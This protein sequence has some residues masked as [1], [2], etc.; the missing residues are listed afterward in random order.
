MLNAGEA[1]YLKEEGLTF[2]AEFKRC[3]YLHPKKHRNHF[4]THLVFLCLLYYASEVE[5]FYKS[6]ARPSASKKIATRCIAAL[7][8]IGVV[9]NLTRSI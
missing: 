4:C 5:F 2:S 3:M 7:G 9:W 6:K 8:F 1:I